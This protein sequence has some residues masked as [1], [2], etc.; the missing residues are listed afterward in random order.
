M[1]KIHV[2]FFLPVDSIS[3]I[4]PDKIHKKL[5]QT[6]DELEGFGKTQVYFG[7]Y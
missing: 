1:A 6:V 3:T 2:D 7:L 4:K 5:K